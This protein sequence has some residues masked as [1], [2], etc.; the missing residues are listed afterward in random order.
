MR[1]LGQDKNNDQTTHSKCMCT[2]DKNEL[3]FNLH[4]YAIYAIYAIYVQFG[5]RKKRLIF[6]EWNWKTTVDWQRRRNTHHTLW[7]SINEVDDLL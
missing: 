3:D 5:V 4:T 6:V 7:N 2:P 1:I